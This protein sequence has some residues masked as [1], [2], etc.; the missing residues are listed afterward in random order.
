MKLSF[1][2]QRKMDGFTLIE[3][4]IVIAIMSILATVV[5][6]ALNPLARFEDSRNSRRWSD[7]EAILSAIKL[8]QVDNGGSYLLNISDL[9]DDIPYLIG[10][11]VDCGITCEGGDVT[12]DA[13]CVDLSD[14]S[15]EGYLPD[16]PVDPNMVNASDSHTGYYLIKHDNNA[17]T[18]GACAAETGSNSSIPLIK[19]KK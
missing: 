11:G 17:I 7:V 9:G 5:F 18:I 12:L 3:L 16:V 8:D 19:V 10:S 13:D 2:F 15:D 6:V 1:L 14:L 4:L